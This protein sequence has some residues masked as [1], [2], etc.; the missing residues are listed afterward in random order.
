MRYLRSVNDR[1]QF[2]KSDKREKISIE[3][4]HH[5]NNKK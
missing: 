2:G 4:C 1:Q 3:G 5:N